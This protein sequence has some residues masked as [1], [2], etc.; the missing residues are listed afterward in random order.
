MKEMILVQCSNC[1]WVGVEKE[2]LNYNSSDQLFKEEQCPNCFT[3]D[4]IENI[5]FTVRDGI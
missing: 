5:G 2:V 3:F 4:T 1:N